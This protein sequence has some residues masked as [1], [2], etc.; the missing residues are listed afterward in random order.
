MP[1]R[2]LFSLDRS[3][4]RA[5]CRVSPVLLV[6]RVALF[7]MPFRHVYGLAVGLPPGRRR[8]SRSER[9]EADLWA[10]R[11]AG[12]RLFPRNPCLA[13]AITGFLLLRRAGHDPTMRLGVRRSLVSEAPRAHAWVECDGQ[14]LVG[15]S[16]APGLYAPLSSAG[17]PVLR[18]PSS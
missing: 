7:A 13:E 18:D 16:S 11:T 5:L 10:V 6:V 4:R 17:G 3:R 12:H 14:V 1:F 15:G 9:L 8:P 2:K